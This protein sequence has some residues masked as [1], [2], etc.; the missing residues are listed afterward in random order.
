[1]GA[2]YNHLGVHKNLCCLCSLELPRRGNSNEH[3]QHRFLRRFDKNY[4]SIIIRGMQV[5]F[6]CNFFMIVVLIVS[7][8]GHWLLLTFVKLNL[9]TL[10]L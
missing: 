2:H 10:I 5:F 7:V 9:M 3:T 4:L 1:M 8:P 6:L